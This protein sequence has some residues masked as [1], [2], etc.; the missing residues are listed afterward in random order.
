MNYDRYMF[1]PPPR[2]TSATHPA[3]LNL[4]DG[5]GWLAQSKLNGTYNVIAVGPKIDE[6]GVFLG[7]QI[8]ATKRDGKKHVRWS[9]TEESARLFKQ[10][11]GKGWYVICAELRND[12]TPHIKNIN[13]IHDLIVADGECL[14]GKTYPERYALLLELFPEGKDKGLGYAVLDEHTWLATTHASGFTSLY[15]RFTKADEC[16]GL[17]LKNTATKFTLG[18]TTLG[19]VKCRIPHKN[20]GF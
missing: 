3:K 20:Y 14:V 11:P 2:P 13:Y 7:T 5:H 16:E 12:K 17:V 15:E 18:D 9:F 6:N 19:M 8:I 10:L 4:Y 1:I